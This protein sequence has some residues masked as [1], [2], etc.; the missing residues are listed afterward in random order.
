MVDY[1][2][3]SFGCGV[4][5]SA[6]VGSGVFRAIGRGDR[7]EPGRRPDGVF[8]DVVDEANDRTHEQGEEGAG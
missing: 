2:G 4:E 6:Q 8:A 1:L 5:R 3:G 7:A